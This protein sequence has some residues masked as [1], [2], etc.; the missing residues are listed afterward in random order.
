MRGKL[1]DKRAETK[2]DGFKRP[3]VVSRRLN[4]KDIRTGN[5]WLENDEWNVEDEDLLELDTEEDTNYPIDM[6][7]VRR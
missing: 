4:K 7:Q 2:S 3:A 1:R 5:V 6:K